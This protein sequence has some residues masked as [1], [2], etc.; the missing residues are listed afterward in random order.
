MA[1]TSR[2]MRDFRL[3]KPCEHELCCL[4][5]LRSEKL[6]ILPDV[7]EQ[8]IDPTSR[9]KHSKQKLPFYTA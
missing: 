4:R 8:L 9:A 2:F 1:E 6:Y 5:I 3:P 7:S